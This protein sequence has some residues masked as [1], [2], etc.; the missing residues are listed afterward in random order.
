MKS[1]PRCCECMGVIPP[2]GALFRLCAHHALELLTAIEPEKVPCV[3]APS[4]VSSAPTQALPATSARGASS[5]PTTA[6]A[7]PAE[8]TEPTSPPAPTCTSRISPATT[9][10]T[11]DLYADPELLADLAGP[12][13]DICTEPLQEPAP[14]TEPEPAAVVEL[15]LA[16]PASPVRPELAHLGERDRAYAEELIADGEDPGE[17]GRRAAC[18]SERSQYG[19]RHYRRLAPHRGQPRGAFLEQAQRRRCSTL[20]V[21]GDR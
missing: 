19:D 6:P 21:P 20:E 1:N 18:A 3:S 2:P 12:G 13:D 4:P 10:A 9:T 14:A 8:A 17:A 15:Q 7:R 5:T 16:P 11:T